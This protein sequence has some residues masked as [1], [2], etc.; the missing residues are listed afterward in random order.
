MSLRAIALASSMI[1]VAACG[2][3]S[4]SSLDINSAPGQLAAALCARI[5][6]C[7]AGA[8]GVPSQSACVSVYTGRLS[9][10]IS[11]ESAGGHASYNASNAGNC[12]NEINAAT[13]GDLQANAGIPACLK[14]VVG[15]QSN[16]AT[17]AHGYECSS[18][19]CA[20][21]GV[22]TAPAAQGQPCPSGS[23]VDGYLC[24]SGSYAAA[25][26]S[27]GNACVC[28]ALLSNGTA[29]DN[30]EYCASGYCDYNGTNICSAVPVESTI[31]P[32][33]CQQQFG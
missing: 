20:G 31:P 29:C 33:V 4:S 7:C 18:M 12:L 17:C 19:L 21:S 32:M 5:Q 6:A 8:S 27:S 24:A 9:A 13:C 16:G 28:A 30:S 22:C 10:S 25:Q 11:S 2:G 3:S 1:F 15:T 23:V 14:I 26:N